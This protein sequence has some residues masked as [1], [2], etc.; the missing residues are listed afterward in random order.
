M[1]K[2]TLTDITSGYA[3]TTA[4]NAN[5]AA[6]EA[7]L[8]NTLS[9]DG[10]SPNTMSADLDMNGNDIL[11]VGDLLVGGVGLAANVTAAAA[12]AAAASASEIAA[13]S[14]ETNAAASEAVCVASAFELEDLE[15]KGNWLTSTAYLRNNIIYYSTD[16]SSYICLV[17]HTSG[18]F[19]T[20]LGSG[21]WGKLAD[22]G[23]AGAGTGDMLKSENLSGLADYAT[24]RSNMGVSAS[25]DTLLKA[26]NLSGLADTATSRTNL[27]LG[28][29]AVVNTGTAS[30]NVPLNSDVYGKQ[31]I[32]I[33]AGAM[34]PRTTNGAASG[35][36]E[37][38]TNKV[39]LKTLDF[40]TATDEYAQF[41]IRMPK[42]W[43]ESTVTAYFVWSHAAT[44]TNFGVVFGLAG[45][46]LSDDDAA[47][48]AFGTQVTVADTGGTTNDIYQT[49][50]TAA[51]T[52]AGSPAAGDWV[53]FQV[54][55]NVSDGSDTMAIDARLHGVVLLYTTDAHNDA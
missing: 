12:S 41:S 53:V 27:G 28:T 32:W 37:T 19:S 3:S 15:Y 48:A 45:V 54:R 44:T 25:T 35:T 11:N 16:G 20:D 40:D 31:T 36:V 9:R 55:R 8:E 50:E 38:T 52:I 43:N 49:A 6:I 10:T 34:V 26:G 51:I 39:M 21:Y 4:I 46:A 24:A 22:K 33:P 30:G 7:A 47:D 23:A 1:A 13:A 17:S 18:T 14:S 2:L 5:N 42:S 29:A